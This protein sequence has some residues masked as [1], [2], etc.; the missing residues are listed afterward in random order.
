[1]TRARVITYNAIANVTAW[2]GFLI[3]TNGD[4]WLTSMFG[5]FIA[6]A[7]QMLV[8]LLLAMLLAVLLPLQQNIPK[9]ML[10]RSLAIGFLQS[11]CVVLLL[12]GLEILIFG[13]GARIGILRAGGIPPVPAA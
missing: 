1:M 5:I 11:S 3:A 6:S 13:A 8:N 4:V 12:T 9:R 10:L 7:P 2:C